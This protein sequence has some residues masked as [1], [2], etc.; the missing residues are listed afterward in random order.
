MNARIA[1]VLAVLMGPAATRSRSAPPTDEQVDHAAKAMHALFENMKGTMDEPAARKLAAE[2]MSAIDLSQASLTQILKLKDAEVIAY[3]DKSPEVDA[4]LVQLA[5]DPGAQGAIAAAMRISFNQQ[6]PS[7]E[8]PAEVQQQ[9]REHVA[10]LYRAALEHPG[11]AASFRTD[12]RETVLGA[13]GSLGPKTGAMVL[14]SLLGLESAIGPGM[15]SSV[16]GDLTGLV[17]CLAAIKDVEAT[18]R[19]QL[20]DKIASLVD[21]ALEDKTVN[22]STRKWLTRGR[23]YL[24]GSHARGELLDHAVPPLDFTWSNLPGNPRGIADLRGKVVVLDFWATWCGP[25]IGSFPKVRELRKR[26]E[27]YDVVILGVT[28]PQDASIKYANPDGS[29]K[30]E[31][32]DTRNNTELQYSLMAE[33]IKHMDM[34]WNVAFTKQDVFNPDFGI[35][36]IPEVAIIDAAGI[37]RHAGLHPSI[38]AEHKVE[39]I[40][41][42]LREAG[43]RVPEK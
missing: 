18:K 40:D 43:L 27:G 24:N 41:G 21:A 2:R 42:L 5:K 6:R 38:G 10:A 23:D 28:S 4:R 11:V 7:D 3:G 20:R 8:Q 13:V 1:L 9:A 33:F 16:L 19:D 14:P 29:G 39:I 22:D 30:P 34:T 35:R 25:C 26:Y 32:V 17:R 15:P 31:S 37:V 12:S 36:G